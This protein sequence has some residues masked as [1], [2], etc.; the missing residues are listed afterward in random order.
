MAAKVLLID[1]TCIAYGSLI[2]GALHIFQG[3]DSEVCT[4]SNPERD[5]SG[6]GAIIILSGF[7]ADKGWEQ[8]REKAEKLGIPTAV[9]T[10][11]P[12]QYGHIAEH[13]INK[14]LD[15]EEKMEK[16]AELLR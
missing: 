3:I 14:T 4:S 11:D 8:L 7:Y 13:V 15:L 10:I 6:Y 16:I 9:M 2:C 5:L 1:N 12:E